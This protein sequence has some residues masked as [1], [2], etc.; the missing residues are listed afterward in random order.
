MGNPFE[1]FIETATKKAS[2]MLAVSTGAAAV[3]AMKGTKLPG[4]GA[5]IIL[6]PA[7][8]KAARKTLSGERVRQATEIL[9]RAAARAGKGAG[10]GVGGGAK[11]VPRVS[12]PLLTRAGLVGATIGAALI[13]DTPR[14]PEELSAEQRARLVR[15]ALQAIEKVRREKGEPYVQALVSGAREVLTEPI[16][17]RRAA[18][19]AA[20]RKKLDRLVGQAVARA[21]ERV[22]ANLKGTAASR[23]KR[24]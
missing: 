6:H 22:R 21:E 24:Y 18:S 10:K 20:Y 11:F 16:L 8:K 13:P 9:E 14:P 2:D 12:G 3:A 5:K 1:D 15:E 7:A 19:N 4:R 23:L 17:T